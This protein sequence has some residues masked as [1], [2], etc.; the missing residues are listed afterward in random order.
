RDRLNFGYDNRFQNPTICSR[1]LPC[2]EMT[3]SMI[4]AGRMVNS[5]A[6]PLG[7]ADTWQRHWRPHLVW[8]LKVVS[9]KGG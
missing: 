9:Y 3:A 4:L 7:S 2:S 5:V 8:P 6:R 1:R